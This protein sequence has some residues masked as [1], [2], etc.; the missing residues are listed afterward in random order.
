MQKA[1]KNMAIRV[2]PIAIPMPA[3]RAALGWDEELLALALGDGETVAV[4]LDDDDA[5]EA[6]MYLGSSVSV[7]SVKYD[8]DDG[9]TDIDKVVAEDRLVYANMVEGRS[10]LVVEGDVLLT[11]VPTP[12]VERTEEVVDD[13][14]DDDEAMSAAMLVTISTAA[15]VKTT[16]ESE[17]SQSV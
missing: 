14:N 12:S 11:R 4:I 17:Q 8:N 13:D 3:P 16:D 6:G 1:A 15:R 9:L 7:A 2:M 10:V 5:V